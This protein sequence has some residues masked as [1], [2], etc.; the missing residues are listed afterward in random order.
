MIYTSMI[1][2]ALYGRYHLDRKLEV[3]SNLSYF[4]DD[5]LRC[6][7]VEILTSTQRNK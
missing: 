2:N 3:I 4:V 6:V 5:G 7:L 1:H